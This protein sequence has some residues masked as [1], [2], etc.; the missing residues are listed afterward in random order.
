MSV[1][2]LIGG[3]ASAGL[4]T[5]NKQESAQ[6]QAEREARLNDWGI[7]RDKRLADRQEQSDLR[8][9]ERE[10]K[11]T[12]AMMTREEKRAEANA[13]RDRERLAMQDKIA[14]ARDATERA[15][16]EQQERIAERRH[17]QTLARIGASGSGGAKEDRASQ[18]AEGYR[19]LA[20][21]AR[22]AG[23]EAGARKYREMADIALSG[24]APP[25]LKPKPAGAAPAPAGASAPAAKPGKKPLTAQ[26]LWDAESAAIN[27]D[28]MTPR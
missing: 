6:L 18:T 8:R 17:Q 28:E 12:D 15:R 3:A 10:G 1:G 27:Y 4:D 16:L 21:E 5:I 19:K 11:R 20:Q 25:T 2:A 26:E 13:A 7:D 24:R 22:E 14:S 9:D 23:D